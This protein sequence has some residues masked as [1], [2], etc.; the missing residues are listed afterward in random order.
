[1]AISL[2]V[3][4]APVALHLQVQPNDK[5][6]DENSFTSPGLFK[7]TESAITIIL[8]ANHAFLQCITLEN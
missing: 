5:P 3:L 8:L 4:A 6:I 7:T 1:M 2:V